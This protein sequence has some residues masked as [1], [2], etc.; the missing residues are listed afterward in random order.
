ME[1]TISSFS[2]SVANSTGSQLLYRITHSPEKAQNA[3]LF[4]LALVFVMF[5]KLVT[6]H[7]DDASSNSVQS[8][9]NSADLVSNILKFGRRSVERY[10]GPASK[11]QIMEAL[12]CAIHAPNHWLCEPWRFR[13][14][15]KVGKAKLGEL[16]SKFKKDGYFGSVPDFLVVSCASVKAK[17]GKSSNFD[18]GWNVNAREDHA[19]CACAVQ[20]F[21][22]SCASQGIGT[23]W[24]TGKMGIAGNVILAECCGL[25]EDQIKQ[26]QYMGTILIG[27]P[28]IRMTDMKVP[29]RKI[30][31][32]SPVFTQCK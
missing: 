3:M 11:D 12:S 1:M 18:E 6:K 5:F 8:T 19:A 29:I 21:M 27:K 7:Y 31:L 30:G 32:Q 24:M 9:R 2:E 15:G 20:N 4:L 22:I 17:N 10:S 16:A 23:K 13:L 14:L 28:Q 25:S 26:E